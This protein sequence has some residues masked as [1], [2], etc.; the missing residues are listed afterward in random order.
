M[1]ARHFAALL[2]RAV[3]WLVT[4][5]RHLHRI[6]SASEVFTIPVATAHAAPLLAAWVREH[7]AEPLLLGPDA[8]SHQWVATVAELAELPWMVFAKRRL[9]DRRIRL[10]LPALKEY[11]GRQPVLLDDIVASGTDDGVRRARAPAPRL[12]AADLP[13]RARGIRGGR[14]QGHHRRG[15]PTVVTTNTIRHPSNAIDVTPLLADAVRR[16]LGTST[17]ADSTDRFA[18]LSSSLHESG[19]RLLGRA[20]HAE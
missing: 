11:K 6:R 15:R 3:D 4:V 9:G 10:T 16:V 19:V 14:V 20:A 1:S 7:V 12:A 2:S 13:G 5:D 17:H 18:A 8:E